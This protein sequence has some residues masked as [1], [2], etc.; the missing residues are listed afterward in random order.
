MGN[1]PKSGFVMVVDPSLNVFDAARQ[2]AEFIFEKYKTVIVSF[3]GGKDST[4][5][6]YIMYETALRLKREMHVLLFDEEIIDPDT[7]A[8]LEQT[9]LLPNIIFHWVCVPLMHTVRGLNRTHWWPWDPAYKDVWARSQP[10]WAITEIPGF[11]KVSEDAIDNGMNRATRLLFDIPDNRPAINVVGIRT[12]ESFNRLRALMGSGDWIT[13]RPGLDYGKPIHDWKWSD[14]WKAIGEFKWPYSAFYDKMK[15]VG[16]SP[17]LQRVAPWGNAAQSRDV[18]F[19][20]VFYP[21]FWDKAIRRLPELKAQARYGNTELFREVMNK[22]DAIT[23]QQY[24]YI[25]LDHLQPADREFWFS[26]VRQVLKKWNKRNSIP[27]PDEPVIIEGY[28]KEVLHGWKRL[29]YIISK[30]DRTGRDKT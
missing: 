4:C 24:A 25:L 12:Q 6:F 18:Q 30:N 19:W 9:R 11:S 15:L 8:I 10:S 17:H 5:V 3:S 7:T 20:P 14:V 16:R 28:G 21:D 2:R 26:F 23:W 13:Q 27:Y 22:P 29:C 1:V